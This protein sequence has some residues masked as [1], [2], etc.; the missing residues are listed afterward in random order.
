MAPTSNHDFVHASSQ[1][2]RDGVI[3]K[4]RMRA[5]SSPDMGWPVKCCS[6]AAPSGSVHATTGRRKTT[7]QSRLATST[8]AGMAEAPPGG[9]RTR[10]NR[11]P[12]VASTG[13][14]PDLFVAG[15]AS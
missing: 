9:R 10:V 5:K 12:H 15:M 8:R 2:A 1:L 3:Y 14:I 4:R 11:H 6:S 13:T 7:P